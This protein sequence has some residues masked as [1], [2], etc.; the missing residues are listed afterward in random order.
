MIE[1][2][3]LEEKDGLYFVGHL[4]DIDGD[5]WVSKEEALSIINSLNNIKND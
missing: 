1:L 4:A 2:K 5:G 3:D